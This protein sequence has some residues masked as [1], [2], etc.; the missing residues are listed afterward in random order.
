MKSSKFESEINT[1]ISR[2]EQSGGHTSYPD[3][4]RL[5]TGVGLMMVIA[6]FILIIADFPFAFDV[7]SLA[8]GSILIGL[9][10]YFRHREHMSI[11]KIREKQID[12]EHLRERQ[13]Y[14]L[15]ITQKILPQLPESS[16]SLKLIKDILREDFEKLNLT[17]NPESTLRIQ[18]E[19]K[20]KA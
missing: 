7:T 3:L 20:N 10:Q 11:L 18:N 16:D 8:W 5:S 14:Q 9:G 1:D 4:Y 12:L 6:S 15:M 19:L 2:Q 17:D 13:T